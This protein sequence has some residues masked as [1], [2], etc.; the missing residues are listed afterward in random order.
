MRS[1]RCTEVSSRP[2]LS[3]THAST[4]LLQRKCACGRM[5]GP[6]G[7]CEA[8]RKKR[9]SL[10]QQT[11]KPKIDDR[12][13]SS[14]PSTVRDVSGSLG[15]PLDQAARAFAHPRFGHDFGSVHI[16]TDGEAHA[17]SQPLSAK[18][19]K[20]GRDGTEPMLQC[21]TF[22]PHFCHSA[23]VENPIPQSKSNFL[24]V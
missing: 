12:N 24:S 4:D 18:A 5:P 1:Q 17:Q 23:P 7:E 13:D 16:H 6:T 15:Q 22:G 2:S 21:L 11:R 8:C 10:S 3:F 19:V 20:L 14:T 9:L